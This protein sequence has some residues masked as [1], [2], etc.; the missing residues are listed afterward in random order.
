MAMH[1]VDRSR[2]VVGLSHCMMKRYIGYNAYDTGIQMQGTT[3][4]LATGSYVHLPIE[5]IAKF[6]M[7]IQKNSPDMDPTDLY[8]LV[9]EHRYAYTRDDDT[10]YEATVVRNAIDNAINLYVAQ[11]DDT[12]LKDLTEY[13]EDIDHQ[14]TEQCSLVGG[15]VWVWVKK[16]LPWVLDNYDI[17]AVEQEYEYVIGCTCG[18]SGLGDV[19]DHESRNCD[20][21]VLMTRPDLILRHKQSGILVYVELKTGADV[22]NYNYSMQYENNVQF[23]LGAIAAGKV[24]GEPIEELYVHALHKGSRRAEYNQDTKEYSGPKRQSSPFCYSFYKEAKPPLVPD[25]LVP[26]YW[27]KDPLTLGRWGATEKKGWNKMPT[28]EMAFPDK[29]G[30]M[31]Y[32]EYVVNMFEGL[33]H[34]ELANHLKFIGPI[35]NP[36]YLMDKLLVEMDAEE[37]R[38]IERIDY[39]KAELEEVG[40]DIKSPEYQNALA[41]VIPRSWD[42]YKYQGWCE[43]Q[44]ICYQKESW[45]DPL[46][47][48]KFVRRSPNHPIESNTGVFEV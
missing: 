35:T 29:P 47:L 25:Q 24:L 37:R 12:G 27:N 33:E 43:Y 28:W 2:Y 1:Y 9:T 46:Q 36:S 40:G 34:D 45:Q 41:Q 6:C 48:D 23:A 39:L 14:V 19:S 11:V 10:P 38:W 30:D 8:K 31:P 42:C 5:H 17:I 4:P 13:P 20:G 21:I 22:K 16:C 26:S 15:L 18:L 44:D 32:Y 3:V 7:D